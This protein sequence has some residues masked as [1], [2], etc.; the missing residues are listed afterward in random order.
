LEWEEEVRFLH[1]EEK[2]R[3][4]FSFIQGVAGHQLDQL[5]RMPSELAKILAIEN[6]QGLYE[7]NLVF[8]MPDGFSDNFSAALERAY[9][10]SEPG[11]NW[12]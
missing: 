11:R 10:K 3:E 7:L 9:A 4:V 5:L 2:F 6:P 1:V 12:S 8:T